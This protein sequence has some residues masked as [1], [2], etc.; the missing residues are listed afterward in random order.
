MGPDDTFHNAGGLSQSAFATGFGG[1]AQD[2]NRR[3]QQHTLGSLG[4]KPSKALRVTAGPSFYNRLS[5]LSS[6]ALDGGQPLSKDASEAQAALNRLAQSSAASLYAPTLADRN[7]AKNSIGGTTQRLITIQDVASGQPSYQ[8]LASHDT[9]VTLN[10]RTELPCL[11]IEEEQLTY[12]DRNYLAVHTV[13]PR[14]LDRAKGGEVIGILEKPG[15][16]CPATYITR[17]DAV[18]RQRPKVTS[19]TKGSA[20][21]AV[22]LPGLKAPD[23]S[24]SAHKTMQGATGAKQL[25]SPDASKAAYATLFAKAADSKGSGRGSL[26]GHRRATDSDLVTFQA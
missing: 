24:R 20:W 4:P 1:R 9:V 23:M 6:K 15:Y 10:H 2:A 19:P 17:N 22:G 18:F 16:A 25:L 21:S 13:D 14:A 8:V 7:H 26:F 3:T 12:G 11:P 5:T